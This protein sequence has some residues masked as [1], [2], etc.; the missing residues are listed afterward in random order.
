M[1]ILIVEDVLGREALINMEH[2]TQVYS[3]DANHPP[4]LTAI[5]TMCGGVFITR[6]SIQDVIKTLEGAR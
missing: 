3:H 6:E 5:R 1:R 2:I 4:N